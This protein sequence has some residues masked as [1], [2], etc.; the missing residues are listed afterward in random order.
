MPLACIRITHGD[1]PVENYT[2]VVPASCQFSK[3]F[4]SL[5]PCK[6]KWDKLAG[7]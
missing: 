3:V 4:A 7:R 2:V 5:V 1:N 6:A